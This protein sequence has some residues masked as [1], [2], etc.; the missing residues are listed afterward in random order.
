MAISSVSPNISSQVSNIKPSTPPVRAERENDG[1][2]DD[3][4]ASK[5]SAAKPTVNTGGEVVGANISVK[6]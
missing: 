4:S 5:V 2:K 6:A 3:G 1:D